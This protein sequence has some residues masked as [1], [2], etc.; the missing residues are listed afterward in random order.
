MGIVNVRH[1]F[2][3][4]KN[5]GV[6][7]FIVV[8]AMIVVKVGVNHRVDSLRCQVVP[9]QPGFEGINPPTDGLLTII[10]L[11]R[12]HLPGVH[13]DGSVPSFQVPAVD[14]NGVWRSV[15]VLVSHHALV[16]LLGSHNDGM[17][18]VSGSPVSSLRWLIRQ[19]G[20]KI[21]RLF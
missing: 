21:R 19:R 4:D 3:V 5:F 1:F 17:N 7:A 16:E 11:N 13:D 10:G 20:R 6:G 8:F 15:I 12:M 9:G 14:G 2:R 18:A